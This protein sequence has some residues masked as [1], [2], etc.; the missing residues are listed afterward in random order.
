MSGLDESKD[1]GVVQLDGLVLLKI[2][3]HCKERV[4]ETVT[5]QLLGLDVEGRLE[6]TNSFPF[7]SGEDVDTDAY[8]ISMMKALRTVNVDNNTV[9]W[10]QSA[11]MANFLTQDLIDAQF[12][13]QKTIP[14]SVVVVYDPTLTNG[15]HLQLSAF[16]LT[17]KFMKLYESGKFT[18]KAFSAFD[19]KSSDILQEIPVKVHNSHL[20]HAFL[21]EL[22]E[23]KSMSCELDRLRVPDSA[24]LEK[25]LN[26]MATAIDEHSTEQQ[27]FQY[28]LRQARQNKQQKKD[29]AQPNRLDA[30]LLANQ[31]GFYAKNVN[32]SAT[33]QFNQGFLLD[34]FQKTE[35]A[36]N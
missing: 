8:Q 15:G 31:I 20:V 4:Y 36:S 22:R 17:D 25:Q 19:I 26:L 9:G 16:R 24:L 10:Y 33:Q 5:G 14:S 21:Y 6:V 11:R 28:H 30:L 32:Q 35:K 2:I 34:G 23:E 27:N 18:Q 13:Y 7:P 29:E 3:K 1:I 12:N